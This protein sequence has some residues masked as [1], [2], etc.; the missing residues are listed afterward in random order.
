MHLFF[1]KHLIKQIELVFAGERQPKPP[2]SS[3][4]KLSNIIKMTKKDIFQ[5]GGQLLLFFIKN[6]YVLYV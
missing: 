2:L 4:K 1:I 5:I 3:E 6:N